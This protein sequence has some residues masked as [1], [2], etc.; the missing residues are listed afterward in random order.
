MQI[1]VGKRTTRNQ[2]TRRLAIRGDRLRLKYGMPITSVN[3]QAARACLSRMR[4]ETIEMTADYAKQLIK[5]FQIM[6]ELQKV[7]A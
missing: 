1:S 5:D 4:A 3:T 2:A 6:E 7:V